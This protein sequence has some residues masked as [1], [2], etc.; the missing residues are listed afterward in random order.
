MDQALT[1]CVD[2]GLSNAG[3]D[4]LAGCTL[5]FAAVFAVH[6][7]L[8]DTMRCEY[9]AI[10]IACATHSYVQDLQYAVLGVEECAYVTILL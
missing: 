5:S 10:A 1:V 8:F 9:N 4:G 3:G 7:E 6:M 2:L